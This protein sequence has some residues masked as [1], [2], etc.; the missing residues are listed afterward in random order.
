MKKDPKIIERVE[1]VLLR[2]TNFLAHTKKWKNPYDHNHLR[3]TRVL[4][5]LTLM[6]LPFH[7]S[8]FFKFVVRGASPSPTTEWYWKEALNKNP[9]WLQ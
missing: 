3:I 6:E 9:E 2:Y 7:A 8:S 4:R 1:V 5:F